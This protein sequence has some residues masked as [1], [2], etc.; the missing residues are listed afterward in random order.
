GPDMMGRPNQF[1]K[2]FQADRAP[3]ARRAIADQTSTAATAGSTAPPTINLDKVSMEEVGVNIEPLRESLQDPRVR[4]VEN[5]TKLKSA[6]TFELP[7]GLLARVAP[8]LLAQTYSK[9]GNYGQASPDFITATGCE[10]LCSRVY[11]LTRA[12]NDAR[13][14]SD[15]KQPRGTSA[16]AWKSKLRWDLANELDSVERD[17]AARPQQKAPFQKYLHKAGSEGAKAE[18]PWR[19]ARVL[20]L[21]CSVCFDSGLVRGQNLRSAVLVESLGTLALRAAGAALTSWRLVACIFLFSFTAL[22]MATSGATPPPEARPRD[23]DLLPDMPP[24]PW[25]VAA[26]RMEC[27][28]APHDTIKKVRSPTNGLIRVLRSLSRGAVGSVAGLGPAAPWERSTSLQKRTALELLDSWASWQG[29]IY[30]V[31]VDLDAAVE[32]VLAGRSSPC[33]GEGVTESLGVDSKGRRALP[34]GALCSV[35]VDELA[36][37]APGAAPF[38]L[39][40]I[41]PLAVEYFSDMESRMQR[42]PDSVMMREFESQVVYRD[43]ALKSRGARLRSAGR[44]WR[45]GVLTFTKEKKES[46]SLFGV[47][48]KYVG[49]EMDGELV[50]QRR[51][52]AIWGARRANLRWGRPP[53]VPGGPAS[54]TNLDLS[55]IE[56]EGR[57]YSA[58]G[59]VPGMFYRLPAVDVEAPADSGHLAL[60]APVAGRSWAPLLAHSALQACMETALNWPYMGDCGVMASSASAKGREKEL[61]SS[62]AAKVLSYLESVGLAVHREEEGELLER[63]SELA[64]AAYCAPPMV[65]HLESPWACRAFMADSSEGGGLIRA[66]ISWPIPARI[67]GHGVAIAQ[68]TVEEIRAESRYCELRGWTIAAEDLYTN[69]GEGAWQEGCGG[70]AYDADELAQAAASIVRGP[71]VR[72]LRFRHLFAGVR[73]PGGLEEHLRWRAESAGIL[74]EVWPLDAVIDPKRDFTDPELLGVIVKP[75][76]RGYFH[77]ALASPPCSTWSRA[78][79]RGHG[80]R[81]LRTRAEPWGRADI[82]LT[83]WERRL[84][85]GTKSLMTALTVIRA[86]C[87]S[88]RPSDPGGPPCPSIW[89]PVELKD[90]VKDFGGWVNY[91]DQCRHGAPSMNPTMVGIFGAFDRSGGGAAARLCLACHREERHRVTLESREEPGGPTFRAAAAQTYQPEFC[92]ALG[93]VILE[94]FLHMGAKR[95]GPDV[96]GSLRSPASA[97][98]GPSRPGRSRGEVRRGDRIR[99]PPLP[100]TWLPLTKWRPLYFGKWLGSEHA[101]INETRAI[102]GLLRHLAR[103]SRSRGLRVLVLTDSAVALGALG[104]GRSSAP[105][106]LR[107]CRQAAAI[108]LAFRIYG[109]YRYAPSEADAADGC[110]GEVRQFPNFCIQRGWQLT[111]VSEV[112]RALADYM[113]IQCYGERKRATLGSVVLFGMLVVWP[114]LRNQLPLALRSLKSWQKVAGTSEGGPLAEEAVYAIAIYMIEQGRYVEAAWTLMQHGV[115]GREQDME[116]LKE[117]KTGTNQGAVIGR[118]GV[119]NLVLGLRDFRTGKDEKLFGIDQIRFQKL[120]HQACRA[121]GMPWAPRPHGIRHTGPGED[122]ARGPASLEKVVRDSGVRAGRDLKAEILRALRM[123]PRPGGSLPEALENAIKKSLAKDV[124]AELMKIKSSTA[125]SSKKANQ[126]D[127]DDQDSPGGLFSDETFGE[128][129]GW[130]TE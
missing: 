49:S 28:A 105:A 129:T 95:L 98:L 76:D 55:N 123:R 30:D 59:D 4:L 126:T 81:P 63:G 84:G 83:S 128:D 82:G 108:T 100:H 97:T 113:G 6:P 9:H 92:D 101:N 7:L 119:A 85:L 3:G 40:V 104:K 38:K 93:E 5:L 31:D 102:V 15:W 112:N 45:G 12:F 68:A 50:A 52:R 8:D 57:V 109:S 14:M 39:I 74:I 70:Y 53:Y 115:R 22:A 62:M 33:E 89:D 41:C 64:A 43:P 29:H 106:L 111:S 58:V 32:R 34:K 118:G 110:P 23:R 27:A 17:L 107:L 66:R 21:R 19:W 124:A 2:T 10:I 116:M 37:P 20:A 36:L 61:V 69:T 87:P 48:K 51:A 122:I 125:R 25:D 86:V 120:W 1:E 24:P 42:Q 54:F 90:L 117:L 60:K 88:E 79:F 94:A 127:D 114:E 73:R 56:A 44:L 103:S 47:I 75:V 46:A 35:D 16:N 96:E 121:L 130:W 18:L 77:G 78:R 65:A 91:L 72:A 71:S 67:L 80:P 13:A 11:A 99:A 26:N